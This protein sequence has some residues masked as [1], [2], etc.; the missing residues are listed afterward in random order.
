MCQNN[1]KRITVFTPTYNRGYIVHRCYESLKSQTC[2][3]FVWLIV[4]DGSTD[5]TKELVDKWVKENNVDI[6]Y[7]KQENGGKQRVHNYG[8]DLCDTELFIC[9]DSDDSLT[10]N[11]I[12]EL[13]SHWDNVKNDENICGIASIKGYDKNNPIGGCFFPQNIKKSTLLDLYRKHKFKGETALLY[14]SDILKQFKFSVADGEK[15]ISEKYVYSQIDQKYSLALLP[16]ILNI[17]EYLPDGY[18]ANI[19]KLSKD[20]PIGYMLVNKQAVTYSITVKE[21]YINTIK[22]IIGCK[23]CGEN[24]FTTAPSKILTAFAYFPAMFLYKKLYKNL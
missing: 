9:V 1:K 16:Q 10:D 22:Y 12:E 8:V 21:K 13:L 24:C 11:A 14:R 5:N 3:D 18:S 20:N 15:F 17:C 2:D 6:R 19:R 7:F 4:D 23:L